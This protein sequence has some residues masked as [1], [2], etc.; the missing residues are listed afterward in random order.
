MQPVLDHGYGYPGSGTWGTGSG[1][2]MG[3]G[4]GRVGVWLYYRVFACMA[5]YWPVW[6]CTGLTVLINGLTGLNTANM[7]LICLNMA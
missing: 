7:A 2:G 5:V 4:S 6:L 1:M 3:T